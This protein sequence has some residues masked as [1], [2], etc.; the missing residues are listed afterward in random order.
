M[1][2]GSNGFDINLRSGDYKSLSQY[3]Y[4]LYENTLEWLRIKIY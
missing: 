2:I 3:F 4:N 1:K